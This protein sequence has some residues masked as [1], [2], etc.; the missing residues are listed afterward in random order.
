MMNGYKILV[1]DD[2]KDNLVTIVD[3]IEERK[4]IG[5]VFHANNGELALM[6]AEKHQPDLIIMDW[7]MP[8]MSGIET[9]K[10]LKSNDKT[11]DIPVIICTGIMTSSNHLETA[12]EAGAVDF[13]RKPIDKIEL[14]SRMQSMLLLSE[15]YKNIK[16]LNNS[17]NTLLSIIAHDLKNPIYT[18]K[19][20]LDLT[21][22]K[23]MT[24][25]K[26]NKI[27]TSVSSSVGSTFSLLENLLSWANSQRNMVAF[28]PCLFSLKELIDDNIK[29]LG[30]NAE[31]KSIL[32]HSEVNKSINVFADRNM[33]STIIRNLIS[34]A[35]KF[36][37]KDGAVVISANEKDNLVEISISDTGCGISQK[38]IDKILNSNMVQST[39]G[40][41]NEI[42]S[43]IGLQLCKEFVQKNGDQLKIKSIE[44]KGSI[45]SFTLSSVDPEKYI[46]QA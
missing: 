44:G 26:R 27:L 32:L 1:V 17:K 28:D 24:E 33:T 36:N 4:D 10:K 30:L 23:D 19:L 43:G 21:L 20:L 15:S 42:G 3:M 37:E 5:E 29:L 22:K 14:H 8:E 25:E 11:K 38:N 18:V 40:T 7:E 9:T 13:I 41:Y 2:Q 34:N 45:F 16:A 39:I 6:I 46:N 12:F 35:I 31:S